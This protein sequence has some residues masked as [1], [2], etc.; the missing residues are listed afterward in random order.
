MSLH[1]ADTD[2]VWMKMA[3]KSSGIPSIMRDEALDIA[4][5][6]GWIDGQA[7][8]IDDTYYLQ[9]YTPRRPRSLWS[10]VNVEKVAALTA[11]GRMKPSGLAEVEAAQQDGRW[12]AA[13]SSPK[14]MVIPDDLLEA[15]R[16]KPEVLAF[17]NG[18]NKTNTYAIVW[19]LETAKK[20]ETRQ[21]RLEAMVA[22]LERGEKLH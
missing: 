18:L 14:T 13:Y 8:S 6:Y 3:R 22:M 17:F 4:L 1:C 12:Q 9:K 19:R 11:A 20:P 7:K 15:L 16:D 10:K 21:R 2:G 5:C